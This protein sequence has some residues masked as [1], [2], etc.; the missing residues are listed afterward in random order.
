MKKSTLNHGCT[1][2]QFGISLVSAAMV[3]SVL[4]GC[5]PARLMRADQYGICTIGVAEKFESVT[6]DPGVTAGAPLGPAETVAA[7]AA[8]LGLRVAIYAFPPAALAILPALALG[9]AR[10]KNIADAAASTQAV[11]ADVDTRSLAKALSATAAAIAP[12][13]AC[14]APAV[15]AGSERQPDAVVEIEKLGIAVSGLPVTATVYA[16]VRWRMV[17]TSTKRELAT[18]TIACKF[19]SSIDPKDWLAPSARTRAELEDMLAKTGEAIAERLF[20]TT[21]RLKSGPCG[22]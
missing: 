3:A 8:E 12:N 22:P 13:A 5:T 20:E 4:A 17:E 2:R 11:I 7:L 15:N 19:P 21:S 14:R 6:V 10:A 16:S 9:T 18:G 1:F